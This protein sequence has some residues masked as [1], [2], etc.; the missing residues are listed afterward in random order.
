ML[1]V[2]A[3]EAAAVCFCLGPGI[4]AEKDGIDMDTVIS[5]AGG[6]PDPADTVRRLAAMRGTL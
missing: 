2:F 5:A 1:A 4:P 6:S 3:E